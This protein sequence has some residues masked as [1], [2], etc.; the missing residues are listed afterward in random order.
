MKKNKTFLLA[1]AAMALMTSCSGKLGTLTSDYFKVNPN[2]LETDAGYV[3]AVINGMFPEKYMQKKAVVTVTP[4][5]RFQ[6]NGQE[7]ALKGESATFQGEKVLGNDQTINYLMGGN[8]A[9]KTRFKYEPAMEKSELWLTFD[10]KMGKKAVEVPAIK[11]AD[12]VNATSELYHQT[13]KSAQP[14]IATDAFQRTLKQKQQANIKFLIQ[15]AELRKSELKSNS[16]QEFIQMLRRIS[17]DRSGLTI[18][19]VEV[20]AYASPDGGYE[21]NKKLANKRQE[22]T[23]EYVKKQLKDANLEADVKTSYTAQDW[24]GFQQLVQ[25]SNIQDKEVVLRVLSMYKDPQER[26]QQIRNISHGF[27]EL[28]DAILPELRRARLTI[29]YETVGRSDAQIKA[30]LQKDA[31]KLSIEELL[32]AASLTD[33]KEEQKKIY[34]LATQYYAQDSRAYNNLAALAYNEGKYDE[35]QQWL[36]KARQLNDNSA[37]VIANR[38]L[39]ALQKGD[40][41][42][43]ETLITKAASMQQ[44]DA[45]VSKSVK[46]ALGNLHLAQG[47]YQMAEK[48]FEGIYSNSAALAQIMN[49]NYSKAK[50]TLKNVEKPDEMTKELMRRCA[51]NE[52]SSLLAYTKHEEGTVD[53]DF[54]GDSLWMRGEVGTV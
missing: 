39:M 13:L 46:E 44:D 33:K 18:S 5:L 50:Q 19:D 45:H 4:E 6:R 26:E 52:R 10:A 3:E 47:K 36:E 51:P 34:L 22:N 41:A 37:E 24:E 27:T 2:P 31:S 42:T 20:S 40:I 7:T 11:V 29:N 14:T 35:S 8:Y 25:A 15:Q 38:G 28:A 48:D 49:K 32:Y 43:A 21:L 1:M 53:C 16:I 30:Q 9:M 17:A 23:E 54:R 12:G